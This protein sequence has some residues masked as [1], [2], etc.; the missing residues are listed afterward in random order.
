M[1]DPLN[2]VRAHYAT[3][4]TCLQTRKSELSGLEALFQRKDGRLSD[5]GDIGLLVVGWPPCSPC[6]GP[7]QKRFQIGGTSSVCFFQSCI[8]NNMARFVLGLFPVSFFHR[9]VFSTT[10]PLCFSVCS[11][12][13]LSVDHVFSITSPVCFQKKVFFF[14]ISVAPQYMGLIKFSNLRTLYSPFGLFNFPFKVPTP[15]L[16]IRL[17]W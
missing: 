16:S 15:M 17:A 4:I 5:G 6:W 8:F 10:S 9:N 1:R 14:C 11:A 13:F 3:R 12:L 7:F 2:F